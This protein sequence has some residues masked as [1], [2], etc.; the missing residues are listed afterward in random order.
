MSDADAIVIGAGPAGLATAAALKQAGLSAVVVEQAEAV[1]QSWRRHY[2]RLHL[3]TPKRGSGL[4]GLAMPAAYPRYPSRKEVVAYFETYAAHHGIAPHFGAKVLRIGKAARWEVE[5]A[6]GRLTADNVV[7]ATGI[8]SWPYCPDWPGRDTYAGRLLHSRDYANP[9]PFAG[10]RGVIVVGFGNSAGEIALDLAEAGIPVSLSVRGAVNVVP[11]DLFGVPIFAVALLQ[12]R[13]PYRVADRLNAPFLRLALGDWSRLGLQRADKGPLA[14]IAEDKRI[15]LLDIGTIDAI[16]R[17]R[18]A[19]RPGIAR[20]AGEEVHFADGS[21]ETPDAII[22]ATGFRPDLRP[23]LPDHSD[24]L[25][26]DG[27]PRVCGAP[28]AH[29]GLFFCGQR[30]APGQLRQI[31]FDAG[32][33]AAAIAARAA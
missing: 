8:A 16:R 30:T 32:R 33:I 7:V 10:S 22:A 5:T 20:I 9:A 21:T 26:N 28:T 27:M 25:E 29:A 31:S 14:Q 12:R 24:A 18:I 2:D 6:A 13:I 23:L 1:G 11:R 4:P 17:G 3:H 19:V 15:P